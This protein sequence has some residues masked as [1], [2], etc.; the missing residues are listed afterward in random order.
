MRQDNLSDSTPIKIERQQSPTEKKLRSIIF[1]RRGVNIISWSLC[2]TTILILILS[3]GYK[4]DISEQIVYIVSSI[5]ISIC[6]TISIFARFAC[7][8]H[9]PFSAFLYIGALFV[10]SFFQISLAAIDIAFTK[11]NRVLNVSLDSDQAQSLKT[12]M[13]TLWNIVFWGSTLIGSVSM[14]FYKIYWTSG[15]FSIKS[16]SLFA[17]QKLLI[18]MAIG[19]TILLACI[20]LLYLF[21][22]K[23]MVNFFI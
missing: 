1:S 20:G 15:R 5:L 12:A 14:N 19:I 3:T 22:K 23:N 11:R 10:L 21:D 13:N 8:E 18:K 2:L 9:F 6:I 17:I 16:K 4:D 7:L